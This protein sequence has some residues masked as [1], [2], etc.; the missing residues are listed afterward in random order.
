MALSSTSQSL[1]VLVE[2]YQ[3]TITASRTWRHPFVSFIDWD[4][5]LTHTTWGSTRLLYPFTPS[6]AGSTSQSFRSRLEGQHTSRGT[7]TLLWSDRRDRTRLSG[8][9]TTGRDDPISLSA[10][11]EKKRVGRG[12]SQTKLIIRLEG[13]LYQSLHAYKETNMILSHG[14]QGGGTS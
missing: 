6:E 10:I 12:K 13:N 2:R 8:G 5:T 4:E 1:A 14:A 3:R 9:M 7:A 11:G